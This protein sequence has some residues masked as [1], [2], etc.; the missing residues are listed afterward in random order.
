MKKLIK[1]LYYCSFIFYVLILFYLLF[2]KSRGGYLSGLPI[3]EYIKYNSNIIPFKTIIRFLKGL[4][5]QDMNYD[6]PLKNLLGNLFILFPM[7]LY[8]T[9]SINKLSGIKNYVVFNVILLV[10]IELGQLLFRRG[11]L[12]IDDFILNLS[13]AMLGY[14]IFNIK[15]VQNVLKILELKKYP[16]NTG[17]TENL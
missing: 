3:G 1:A 7:G 11:S 4:V 14:V 10:C 13:G 16:K 15:W 6:I 9:S 17:L 2:L 5:N 12:D 8:L